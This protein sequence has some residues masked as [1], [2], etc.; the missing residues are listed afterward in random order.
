MKIATQPPGDE[1]DQAELP[2]SVGALGRLPLF[3]TF[4]PADSVPQALS[5]RV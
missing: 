5:N 4:N 2:D 1:L 3:N